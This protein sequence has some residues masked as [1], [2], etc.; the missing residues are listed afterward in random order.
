MSLPQQTR[1]TLLAL[2]GCTMLCGCSATGYSMTSL[3]EE[4]NG[5][6]S[7]N[8]RRVKVGDVLTVSFPFQPEWNHAAQVMDDG[9]ANFP[10]VGEVPVVG[11]SMQD[12]NKTLVESYESA[13]QGQN[14]QLTASITSTGDGEVDANNSLFV[15]GEVQSPGPVRVNGKRI[16][17]IEAISAAGGHL[18]QTANLGNTILIRRIR[19]SGAMRSWRLDA[20]VYEWGEH[21]PIYLQERDVVFVPNTAIDEVDIF[22]DQ[23]IRQMLPF[24]MFPISPATTP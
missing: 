3:A 15:I 18:K 17:L 23:W 2:I 14:V 4:I 10:L 12:L 1:R 16:T 24:P 6:L 20:D 8:A 5:T 13:R 7:S 19:G 11:L 22:V 9:S 21:P